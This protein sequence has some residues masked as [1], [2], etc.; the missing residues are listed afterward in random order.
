MAFLF[1]SYCI[2]IPVTPG[3]EPPSKRNRAAGLRH[4]TLVQIRPLVNAR[5]EIAEK[6]IRNEVHMGGTAN[7]T[8]PY[9]TA[10][11]YEGKADYTTGSQKGG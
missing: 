5:T 8:K 10:M 7:A 9:I 3:S 1:L 11:F 4:F 2:V 6:E